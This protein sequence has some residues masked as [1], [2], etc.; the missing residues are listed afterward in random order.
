MPPKKKQTIIN[1]QQQDTSTSP[2]Q[3]SLTPTLL[4][5]STFTHIIHISDLHIRPNERHEEYKHVFSQLY[6]S[7][8]NIKEQ[9]I[10]A[11][12]VITGD[13]FDNK[14]RFLPEQYELCSDLFTNLSQIFPLI[15]IMG[16][17]DMKD[18][19]RLDS[20]TPSA[21]PRP[22][23]Y[24]LQKSG[25]YK[26]GDA[27]FS[28]T[29]LYDETYPFIKR[30]NIHTTNLCIALYHGTIA[31][32]TTDDNYTL[33]NTNTNRFK[34]K[35]DFAGYDAVLLGDIHKMQSLTPTMWYS[36]SLIQQNYG[37]SLRNHG[38][39][40]WDVTNINEITTTFHDIRNDY[41]F[42]TINI[43]NGT[44]ENDIPL[45]L[46]KFTSLRC[47][48]K[49]TI[50][51]QIDTILESMSQ[52]TKIIDIRIID[53]NTNTVT[54]TETTTPTTNKDLILKELEL[55][56][57]TSN[58]IQI[59]NN[60]MKDIKNN[61]A[62]QNQGYCWFP[63]SLQFQNLFGYSKSNTNTINFKT[64]VTSITG[65]N[66]IG[67][68]SIMN[69]L[70]F[71]IFNKLLYKGTQNID[72]LNN[73]ES[74]GYL[75]LTIQ[76]NITTYTIT[77]EL[78]R[79]QINKKTKAQPIS[80]S[81]TIE[82]ITNDTQT[83]LT[84]DSAITKL[85]EL[86]GDLEDFHK[87][88]IL[89]NKD[90]YNDF[91]ALTNGDKI[92]Y[93]KDI[94]QLNYF[95][96]LLTLNK[97]KLLE[98]DT[99][100]NT[101]KAE[102]NII[103]K[104]ISSITMTPEEI[105]EELNKLLKNENTI[106]N[107]T[108]I[109]TNKY[110]MTQNKISQNQNKIIP[111]D[112]TYEEL[113]NIIETIQNK[114]P[115]LTL[116]YDIHELKTQVAIKKTQ[117]NTQVETEPELKKQLTTI[118]NKLNKINTTIT[119]GSKDELYKLKCQYKP[120][121]TKLQKEIADIKT[122]LST[123][124]S[125]TSSPIPTKSKLEL[126]NELNTLQKQY[127]PLPTNSLISINQKIKLINTKL[128][129]FKKQSSLNNIEDIIIKKTSI[130]KEIEQL[131]KEISILAEELETYD[132]P[133]F[134]P[135]IELSNI[136]QHLET[137]SQQIKPKLTVQKKTPFNA[138][139]H[140]KNLKDYDDLIDKI[141]ALQQK[142]LTNDNID[143]YINSISSLIT[144]TQLTK[145]EFS[146]MKTDL[147][148]PIKDILNEIKNN[149]TDDY[150]NELNNLIN[151]KTE[152]TDTINTNNNIIKE[153]INIDNAIKENK[154]IT[155]HNDDIT[156]Q[157]NTYK[158]Y[159]ISFKLKI[160]HINLVSLDKELLDITDSYNYNNLQKELTTYQQELQ[161]I[162]YNKDLDNQICNINIMLDTITYNENTEIFK[163]KENEL[164]V[165]NEK[166]DNIKQQYDYMVLTDERDTIQDKLKIIASNKVLLNEIKELNSKIM[167]EE[168]RKELMEAKTKLDI[169][170]SNEK[171]QEIVDALKA[172]LIQLKSDRDE[173]QKKL[174]I[175]NSKKV[176]LQ[177]KYDKVMKNNGSLEKL[178]KSIEELE[179]VK[180]DLFYYSKLIGPKNLQV[181][182]IKNELVKLEATMNNILSKYTKYKV[183]IVYD[184]T[185]NVNIIVKN[186]GGQ[187][188]THLMSAY[189][190]M[191]LLTSFKIAISKHTN[192]SK[193]RLFIM[194]E[195]LENMDEVNFIQSLPSLL[196]LIL[197][198]YSYILM[199]SQK[200][201]KHVGCTEIV[202]K[203]VNGCSLIV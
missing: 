202:I 81:T 169:L 65:P 60:Y 117:L 63:V 101:K 102:Q 116:T 17:H 83:I 51:S 107:N 105:Q 93:L 90:Q 122:M 191:I 35:T 151:A 118:T 172:T 187:V 143:T 50:Q 38:F 103:N 138:T 92:K 200:D 176:D 197:S 194:D 27:I 186:S 89:N 39:L 16:N 57:D 29:S 5:N 150:R 14:N 115:D 189:E 152:L 37:E 97:V 98:V 175:I 7:I 100:L 34:S 91:F 9:N 140:N 104:E 23:F 42:I 112:I 110:D 121:I 95:D 148:I 36:G 170:E 142:T 26:Y 190:N 8:T 86:F 147:L 157:I 52:Y 114:Y 74:K 177:Y 125:T 61:S 41:G 78:S 188:K 22:N 195:S 44:C 163:I 2:P 30:S 94:F 165:I 132:S 174:N 156:Q 134:E 71:G 160:M 108:R 6:T 46:P 159:Q 161:T 72:I 18:M 76:H 128:S 120:E 141:N 84:S 193:G 164:V 80:L 70:L 203:K 111:V 55:Q 73:E 192:R 12:I 47:I 129:K 64:G 113:T 25:V 67:K 66:T 58:I 21:Y 184:D 182:I 181:S 56:D 40:L 69:I 43:T 62:I 135:E 139:T 146:E 20:I 19:T 82:F 173:K 13:I 162:E 32:S 198:E 33:N 123:L 124:K 168:K 185:Q 178:K 171:Y 87:C 131:K 4:S 99:M 79:Q 10:N 1:I 183:N 130:T 24:Y 45:D 96:E 49:N 127:K 144:K 11:I 133:T 145:S 31:G 136:P 158:Y 196:N 75:T 48:I 53:D 109:V 201:V 149:K 166:L 126:T 119:S 155:K 137:L 179:N 154:N 28:V 3:N 15:V 167:Y 77:K 180:K 59:H 68:T 88:N 54:T 199:V 153:N 85:K 106:L